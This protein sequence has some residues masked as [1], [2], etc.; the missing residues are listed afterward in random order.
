MSR[1]SML[2]QGEDVNEGDARYLASEL[3]NDV[4]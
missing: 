1:I 4:Y 2:K 3:L